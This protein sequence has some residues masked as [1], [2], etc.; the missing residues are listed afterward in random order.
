MIFFSQEHISKLTKTTNKSAQIS[1]LKENNYRFIVNGA[2][3]PVVFRNQVSGTSNKNDGL[4]SRETIARK[5]IPIK[6]I[7]GVYFLVCGSE[8]MYVGKSINL[9]ERI[10]N[11]LRNADMHFD[12]YYYVKEKPENLGILE[13][14][15]INELSPRMNKLVSS[16]MKKLTLNGSEIQG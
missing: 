9:L 4:L 5:S 3:N 13:Q 6:P 2:G 1:W 11:H 8:I 10:G 16:K 7:C 14:A 12:S 15:Y